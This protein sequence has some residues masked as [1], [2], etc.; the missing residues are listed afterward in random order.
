MTR[1]LSPARTAV[2]ATVA[3]ALVAAVPAYAKTAPSRVPR[4]VVAAM[5]TTP[6]EFGVGDPAFTVSAAPAALPDANNAGE[7]S[8]G[9]SWKSGRGLFMAGT[10]TY[11]LSFDDHLQPPAVTWSDVSSP[12]SVFN[13][14][15]IL[16]TDPATGIT[17]AG[18]DDSGCA[19][20]S[21][22][23]DD[24]ESWAASMPCTG[25]IDHPT[26]GLGRFAGTPPLGA[27]GPTIG[28]FCQQYPSLNQCSR[29]LDG[30]ST[31]SP[32]V[33]V[34]GCFGLFGH[35]K[36]GPDGAAYVP[37]GTCVA[38]SASG[39][40]GF[41]SRDDGL[42]WTSY[43][44]PGAVSPDRGFDPS[45]ALTTDGTLVEAW[46]RNGD[47]HPVVAVST[48]AVQHWGAT[49]DLAATVSPPLTGSS[50]PTVVAGGPG[51]AAV[52]FLGTRHPPDKG[53][54]PY[55]DPKAVWDLYVATTYDGGQ[56]WTTTQVTTDPVQ[57]GIIA[58]GG[59]AATE[60]RNL[61]DF[62]DAGVN[63]EGR[64]VVGFADGCLAAK[65]CTD[66]A[67]DATTSTSQW[68]TVAY[69]ATGRGMFA[70]NDR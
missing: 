26:V 43:V 58:D 14:D 9:L 66:P 51:R 40:G 28:Y 50:F 53:L 23:V 67:A 38:G 57:R 20:L 17:L 49:V 13:L 34:T 15:P 60:G 42:T 36:V 18:G 3:V 61:L 65:G 6:P 8:L 62:M 10:S 64:I 31:W 5:P 56:T 37:S 48:G 25:L 11:K 12:Y 47:A 30:G 52:A 22:S 27:S 33:T 7:P 45:V 19:V 68:A 46:S 44:I 41:V 55:D 4:A 29:S 54:S 63:R 59:L 35:L 16:A 24:G 32:G 21:R 70:A 39:V 69:Q 1:R 2:L